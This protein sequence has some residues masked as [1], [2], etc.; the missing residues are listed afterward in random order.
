MEAAKNFLNSP[1]T[2]CVRMQLR[3]GKK[4]IYVDIELR[5]PN[6]YLLG[7]CLYSGLYNLNGVIYESKINCNLSPEDPALSFLRPGE[8]DNVTSSV[9]VHGTQYNAGIYLLFYRN[10]YFYS[11][12]PHIHI[13]DEK[14]L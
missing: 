1:S 7:S 8:K 9:T 10:I 2:I 14:S 3:F 12:C 13:K 5:I 4:M 11:K 6:F